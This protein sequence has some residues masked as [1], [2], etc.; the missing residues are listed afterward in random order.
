MSLPALIIS[1]PFPFPFF[2]TH[3]SQPLPMSPSAQPPIMSMFQTGLLYGEQLSAQQFSLSFP[4]FHCNLL[5][6]SL[7]LPFWLLPFFFF[8]FMFSYFFIFFLLCLSCSSHSWLSKGRAAPAQPGK[9]G[10]ITK[11]QV[12]SSSAIFLP[13]AIDSLASQ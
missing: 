1:S 3:C 10:I 13:L 8:A 9:H 2:T 4:H 12:G 6:P 5:P 7:L 11:A